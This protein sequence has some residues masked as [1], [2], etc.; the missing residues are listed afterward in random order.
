MPGRILITAFALCH[1][2][3]A[4]AQAADACGQLTLVNSVK[5]IR[6]DDG[7]SDLVPLQI[8]G[9][10][11][12]FLFDTGGVT[13]MMT[14]ESAEKL[15]LRIQPTYME[16]TNVAGGST[17]DRAFVD[18]F[19]LGRLHGKDMKF[20]IAPFKGIDGILSLNFL[21]PYDADVDFGTDTLNFFSQDHCPGDVI[22]WKADPVA[23]VPFDIG[24]SH[25]EVRVTLDGEQLWAIIDTGAS[26]TV[27]RNDL[28]RSRFKLTLGDAATPQ[29]QGSPDADPHL[30]KVYTH[31]FKTLEFGSIQLGNPHITIL[32][33]VYKRD[34]GNNQLVGDRTKTDRDATS[35]LPEVIIGMNVL[36]KL[37]VY[38]A[39]KERK[40]YIS[41]ASGAAVA[42]PGR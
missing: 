9:V 10:D 40:M 41:A 24:N 36:R 33:D 11:Q 7:G 38:F 20:P 27:L 35:L 4:A 28:A 6:P 3:V 19:Q 26:D 37:H 39:F 16:I 13:T 25:I 15:K 32:E 34:A 8:N 30:P 22:Y 2:G 5:M 17:A 21:L 14:R 12:Q 18:Q 29:E 1:I 31:T 42:T 23:V